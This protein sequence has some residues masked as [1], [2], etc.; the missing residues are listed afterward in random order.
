MWSS[1]FISISV[2]HS[3]R[4]SHL[5]QIH[6]RRLFVLRLTSRYESQNLADDARENLKKKTKVDFP[7]NYEIDTK[8]YQEY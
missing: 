2:I 8:F 7:K 4:D 1:A 3:P 5:R 6:V